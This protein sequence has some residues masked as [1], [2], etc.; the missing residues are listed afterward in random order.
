MNTLD[1]RL[2][3]LNQALLKLASEKKVSPELIS[4]ATQTLAGFHINSGP[5]N[6][7]IIINKDGCN[8]SGPPGPPGEQGPP[9]PPGKKGPPGPPGPPGTCNCE[10]KAIVVSE[11]YTAT[12]NDYYI[13][14]NS[15]GPV[16]ITLPC[17][18][19]TCLEIIVKAE[20]GP[21]LGNRKITIV[22]MDENNI[23][24]I[25]GKLEYIIEVPYDSVNMIYRGGNW[26]IV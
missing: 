21:P 7:T 16:T 17:S 24:T 10:C 19:N 13:G 12:S 5:G 26:W 22:A 8:T 11:D 3:E 20:M 6:D 14:V 1:R 2:I 18:G 9:G 15:E 4:Q 23:C 25:D